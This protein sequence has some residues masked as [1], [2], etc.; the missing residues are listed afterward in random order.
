MVLIE[1]ENDISLLN[2]QLL[3]NYVF[4]DEVSS[5]SIS[6]ITPDFDP[7][8]REITESNEFRAKDGTISIVLSFNS[9]HVQNDQYTLF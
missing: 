6:E 5:L 1:A 8:I 2:T 7:I 4:T 3:V 9:H